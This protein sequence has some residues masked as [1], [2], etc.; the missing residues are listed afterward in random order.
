MGQQSKSEGVVLHFAK[1]YT[2]LVVLTFA[3]LII[4]PASMQKRDLKVG[5]MAL[6]TQVEASKQLSGNL[7]P[8]CFSVMLLSLCL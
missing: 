3:L 5:L 2:P 7:L 4:V 8:C 1:Y 6:L